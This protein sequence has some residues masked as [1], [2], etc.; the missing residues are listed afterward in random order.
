LFFYYGNVSPENIRVVQFLSL[1][2]SIIINL[3][4]VFIKISFNKVDFIL[5][6]GL[7]PRGINML[8]SQTIQ[9]GSLIFITNRIKE[10]YG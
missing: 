8:I 1:V 10:Y 2:V 6:K 3:R 9:N 5:I 7:V 4:A